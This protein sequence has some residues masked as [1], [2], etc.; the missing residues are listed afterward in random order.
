MN[1]ERGEVF[2]SYAALGTQWK[3][4]RNPVG[5]T[6]ETTQPGPIRPGTDAQSMVQRRGGERRSGT[7]SGRINAE[8]ALHSGLVRHEN[9]KPGAIY[10]SKGQRGLSAGG[11]CRRPRPP[12]WP[13]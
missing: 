9:A 8:A 3:P 4:A 5:N 12:A 10:V 11:G 7:G 1:R 2:A 6:E 13:G